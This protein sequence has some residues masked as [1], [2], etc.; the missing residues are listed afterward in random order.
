MSS[1]SVATSKPKLWVSR[2]V[3]PEPLAPLHQYFDVWSEPTERSLSPSELARKLAAC[4]AAMVGLA[5]HIGASEIAETR[6]LRFIANM[7]TGYDNLD[8]AAL[9]AKRIGA[10]NTPGVLSES[11]AEF[12]WALMLAASRRV[13]AADRWVRGGQWKQAF[14]FSDWLG[15]DLSG[16]TLG[17]LGL[18]RIGQAVARRAAAFRM[19]VIYHNRS[20]VDPA[21]ESDC[22]AR[23]V[24]MDFLLR[25]SDVLLVA[26]PA[27][28]G[29][30][31]LLGAGELARMKA[32]AVL[33]NVAR[34]GIVD[35]HALAE[36]LE[37]GR[38]AAAALDVFE[39]EPAILPALLVL[40]NVILTPHI[41]S[42]TPSTRRAMV[43]VAVDNVMAFFGFG[44]HAGQPPN[45]L[46]P[47][48]LSND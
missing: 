12:A 23:Y 38:I 10:S 34:G 6:R 37:H 33:V 40:E 45:L 21:L 5:D 32:T 47:D 8:L 17:I 46:N 26:I 1:L 41:A 48:L 16:R 24:D 30:R 42:A 35:E 29:T 4:D 3:P 20:R 28:S 27:T 39:G 14:G 19:P 25:S 22:G 7:A 43:A 18:G 36:A 11:V 9:S 44:T 13:C 31:H 2:P 15:Y